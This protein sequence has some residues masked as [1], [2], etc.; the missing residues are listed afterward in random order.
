MRVTFCQGVLAAAIAINLLILYYI[1]R[2][3][4]HVLQRHRVHAQPSSPQH[5]GPLRP[6]V[7]ILIRDFEDFENYVPSVVR[8]FLKQHPELPVLVVADSWPYPP[9]LLPKVPNV[10]LVILKPSPAQPAYVSRPETY[11]RTEYVALVP[12]GVRVD[13]ASQLE[14]LLEELKSSGGKVEMVAAP[15]HSLLPFRCLHLKVSLREWTAEY[16]ETPPASKLCTALKGTAVVVLPTKSLFNLS[17]PLTKPLLTSLFIQS[18]LR[19]WAVRV[20]DRPFSLLHQPLLTSSHNQ[21]KADNL[22]KANQLQLFRDFGIKQVIL[23]DG[24]QQWFGCSKETPRCF[25]T[26]QDDTPEYLYQNR[27]TPPCCLKALRETAKYVVNVL[28]VS[29]VRYW[30]E[31]GSLLGAARHQDII[32]WDYD[33]DLGIYLED[34]PNCELLRGAESGSIVDEKGFVWEKAIEGDFYR[35]QYSEHNHLHVDLWP[36]YPKDGLMTKDA[37]MD[38]RQDVE[39]PEHFLKPLVPIEFAGFVALAPNN[40]R[41]FLELKFGEGVIENPEYPNPAL[42]SMNAGR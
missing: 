35:V 32:P 36:F 4:Q 30:L 2:L 15:V 11:V 29:G 16:S 6:G 14:E 18:S 31:G 3:Q 21:W 26:I 39:F 10:Q 23:E 42:K 1:S 28:E 22:A 25:G 8:S 20:L 9:L 17:M 33:V 24:K 5:L 37:W 19:G 12:D 41:S 13:S 40:Y 34:I 38:H 7:T 27:W